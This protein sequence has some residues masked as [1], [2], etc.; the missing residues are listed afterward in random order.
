MIQAYATKIL[1]VIGIAVMVFSSGVF[2]SYKYMKPKLELAKNEAQIAIDANVEMKK[3]I[4]LREE[5]IKRATATCSTRIVA[6]DKLIKEYMR[7]LKL[8]GVSNEANNISDGSD[9]LSE[10]NG[11]WENSN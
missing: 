4:E 3:T 9:I 5:E 8:K 7:I 2:A 6:K 1:I 10:L 11:L